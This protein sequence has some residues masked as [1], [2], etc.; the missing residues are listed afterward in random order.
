MGSNHKEKP[1]NR[2]GVGVEGRL[3][4]GKST[5]SKYNGFWLNRILAEGKTRRPDITW[6]LVEYE[7]FD[8]K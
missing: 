5:K 7:D 6:G 2:V 1:R 3:V 4:N 8:Q